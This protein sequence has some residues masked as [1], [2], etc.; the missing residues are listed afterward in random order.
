MRSASG[1]AAW[2]ALGL[3]GVLGCGEKKPPPLPPPTVLVAPV[4][5]ED[6]PVFS[7]YVATVEGYI[8]V[9]IRARVVG[10]LQTQDYKDGSYVKA[11]ELLFTIDPR[12]YQADVA[13]AQ[14]QVAQAQA[15]LTRANIT[16]QRYRPLAA[17]QAISQQDL[18][19]AIASQQ[20][21]TGL[22][23]SAKGTLAQAQLN[24]SYTRIFSPVN[25][26]AG[27][28]Q[29]RIGNLVGQGV[30]TLLTTVSQV[31]PIRVIFNISEIDYIRYASLV[32][33]TER[34]GEA[35]IQERLALS[36]D[37]GS[38]M[39]PPNPGLELILA[40]N[41]VYKYRGFIISA[42]RQI[43]TTTGT[44]QVEAVFPNPDAFLRPGLYARVRGQRPGSGK[45][46][47]LIPQ[48]AV[49]ELQGTFSVAVVTPE[50]KVQIRK[51]EVGA[52][53]GPNW[54][55]TQGLNAGE[56]V[57]VEG[58]QKVTDGAPVKPQPAASS[59]PAPSPPPA[60]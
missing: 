4:L 10:F 37:G 31:D 58:V 33:S 21:S 38:P 43:Q 34:L 42:Q 1:K 59:P 41:S 11:G 18:D 57:I 29:V 39:P 22:L 36:L 60:K 12:Q 35:V 7:D 47:L 20:N 45:D 15:L 27:T 25:G 50:D 53:V 3:A 19:N 17:K 46:T 26:V 48:K 32:V 14:G 40:D 49:S 52:R 9:D 2:L 44:L 56:R 55:I 5:K 51:V 24:L 23:E 30:P 13:T 16:V 8:N 54:I 6:V 28:A